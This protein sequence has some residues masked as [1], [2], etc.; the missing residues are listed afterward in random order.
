[1]YECRTGVGRNRNDGVLVRFVT[2]LTRFEAGKLLAENGN[3]GLKSR[4]EL[5]LR[6][7]NVDSV[8]CSGSEH[9]GE[10]CRED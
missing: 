10:G 2:F 3:I 8:G 9:R 4:Q 1:M 6:S 7:E 5:G